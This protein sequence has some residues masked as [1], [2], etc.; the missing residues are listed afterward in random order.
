MRPFWQLLGIVGVTLFFLSAFT[1]LPNLLDQ[2][3][4]T[5]ARIQPADAIVVLG[6]GIGRSGQLGDDSLRRALEGMLLRRRQLAPFLVF[7]GPAQYGGPSEADVR[8]QLAHELGLSPEGILTEPHAWTTREEAT[9]IGALLQPR[10]VRRILLVTDSRHMVRARTLFEHAR[11][12]VFPAPVDDGR[13]ASVSPGKRLDLT[14]RV[15]QEWVARI[16]Y[17][18]AGYL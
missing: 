15:L 2:H 11:F 5:P 7:S 13:G 6:A 10:H 4:A 18:A 12:E 16:Y 3:L 17:R 14:E 9:R 8:A 1:P